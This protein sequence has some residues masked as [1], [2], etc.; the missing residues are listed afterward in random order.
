VQNDSG[1][2]LTIRVR[3]QQRG[4]GMKPQGDAGQGS[5]LSAWGHF[6]IRN[7]PRHTNGGATNEFAISDRHGPTPCENRISTSRKRESKNNSPSSDE[8]AA[9]RRSLVR[10][11]FYL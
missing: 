1:H 4:A 7:Q 11:A 6:S 3:A 2:L 9:M 10:R 5:R 8:T